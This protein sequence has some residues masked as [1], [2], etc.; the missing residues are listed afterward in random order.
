MNPPTIIVKFF[1]PCQKEKEEIYLFHTYLS[2]TFHTKYMYKH[3]L[4]LLTS[5]QVRVEETVT[6]DIQE[7]KKNI[8]VCH[9]PN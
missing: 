1:N 4:K 9:Y 5:S 2:Y 8:E 7:T 3:S 6:E